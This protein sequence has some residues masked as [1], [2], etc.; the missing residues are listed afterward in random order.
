MCGLLLPQS[1]WHL[2]RGGKYH[3]TLG[4]FSMDIV[5]TIMFF[6]FAGVQNLGHEIWNQPKQCTISIGNEMLEIYHTFLVFHSPPM[7][8]L[9]QW[10]LW[11]LTFVLPSWRSS[12]TSWGLMPA[13]A[14]WETDEANRCDKLLGWWIYVA[15]GIEIII[16][17]LHIY[18]YII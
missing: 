6:F 15:H 7:G 18:I 4:G 11:K 1:E 9:N 8:N 12:Q 3:Q 17:C 16:V 2:C 10:S 13:S 14:S 5:L